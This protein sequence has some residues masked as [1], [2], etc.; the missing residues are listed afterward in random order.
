MINPIILCGG[1]GTRLWPSSRRAYPKQFATLLGAE[2]LFQSTLKRLS[3]EGF[4]APTIMTNAE[5]RFIAQDQATAIG[6]TDA[7]VIIEPSARNTAPAILVAALRAEDPETLLLAA[8]SDH[9]VSDA[10]AFRRTILGAAEVARSGSIVVFGIAPDRPDTGYG[11]LE[12]SKP[13]ADGRPVPLTRFTEKPDA[14][15][16]KSFL[17]LGNY[18]WNAGLFLFRAADMVAAFEAY[19]PDL[20]GPCRAALAQ[21]ESD[22]GFFRLD[23][24]AWAG[25]RDISIDYAVMEKAWNVVA[26]PYSGG[27]SDLGAWDAIWEALEKDAAGVAT[28]GTSTAIDCRD[29]LLRAEGDG[30]R[31]VG[32]GLDGV[33]AVAMGDAVLVAAKGAAQRVREVVEILKAQGAHQATEYPR[34]HRPWGWYETLCLGGRFQVKRI[35]VKPSGLLSLQSHIHRAEHWIVVEGTARVTIG[36]DVRLLTENQS[37]YV[38]LGARHRLEN[39]GKVPMYLVEVQTGAYLGEDDIVRYDDVYRRG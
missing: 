38:P 20:L 5:F 7:T 34:F 1:S 10:A 16:A 24:R 36:E 19:A 39:P 4:A 37:I 29:T 28:F 11:W 2:T 6:L 32:L 23:G 21:A 17:A 12:L 22:L 31:L 9:L 8:P 33:I 3:G 14:A 25:A 27:W 13:A 26:V 15:R 35:M 18:L 30:V